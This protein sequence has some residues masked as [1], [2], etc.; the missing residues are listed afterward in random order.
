[1]MW[2][3]E[4]FFLIVLENYEEVENIYIGK[5]DRVSYSNTRVSF[6]FILMG[7]KDMGEAL[8]CNW[9]GN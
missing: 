2:E 9:N 3:N 8:E 6:S 7:R 4:F 5:N 1:M